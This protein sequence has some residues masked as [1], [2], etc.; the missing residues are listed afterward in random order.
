[1]RRRC[2]TARRHCLSIF[3]FFTL[4]VLTGRAASPV[5]VYDLSADFSTNSN[6]AGPWSYGWKST[7]PGSFTRFV[8]KDGG[9]ADNGVLL[10]YWYKPAGPAIYVNPTSATATSD[11]GQGVFPPGTVWFYPG[12]EGNTD[13]YGI[14]RFIVPAAVSGN[15]LLESGVRS[16]LD[17]S[18]SGDTDFHIV[19]NGAEIF[20]PFLPPRS[21]TGFT[22]SVVL[23][24]GDTV[25]FA[26]GRG[27]DNSVS[28][29]GL[30][31]Q[32][33][34]TYM[35]TNPIPPT[36]VAQPQDQSAFVG[37]NV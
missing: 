3:L 27:M 15:Y 9:S 7:L 2:H 23:A 14:I 37:T 17:G 33:T 16:Y 5:L 36:I 32:A 24:A 4:A 26:I 21:G 18:G 13:N 1:M 31:I 22:N 8:L 30:K 20:G 34:L 10:W 12:I 25:D 29:S 35:S 19:H 11:G 28:G 6:P